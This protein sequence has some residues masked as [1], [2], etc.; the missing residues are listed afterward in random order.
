L[1]D[2]RKSNFDNFINFFSK[3]LSKKNMNL[4]K[5][6][7]IYSDDDGETV[8]IAPLKKVFLKYNEESNFNYLTSK[9]KLYN[10]QFTIEFKKQISEKEET[11]I[12]F[13]LKNI[14]FKIE[15]KQYIDD[16]EL[17]GQNTIIFSN[18][19]LNTQYSIS[20]DKLSFSSSKKET[21]N[22]NFTYK[23]KINL[24]P[25]EFD[26]NIKN[27]KLN[28]SEIVNSYYLFL[29]MFR[30]KIIINNNF[31]GKIN[32][33]I[34]NIPNS[35]ILKKAKIKSV[36]YNELISFDDSIINLANF[37]EIKCT[38]CEV[39]YLNDFPEFYGEFNLNIKNEN[40]FYRFFQVPLKYRNNLKNIFFS[41]KFNLDNEQIE[42]LEIY[43]DKKFSATVEEDLLEELN[44]FLSKKNIFQNLNTFR[45]F[46]NKL[47]STLKTA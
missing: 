12:F 46:V 17:I 2:I 30:N 1:I 15:N 39:N 31:N 3:K 34:N 19:E 33:K 25:F 35:K 40:S 37:G 42:M 6:K 11:N 32:F 45:N 8:L 44:I 24:K 41:L 18:K 14:N 21:K 27:N 38:R 5:T 23:G 20:K 13:E 10:Q 7:I 9:G 16:K 29:E 22:S 4:I 26:V 28:L 36:F 43:F 47:F